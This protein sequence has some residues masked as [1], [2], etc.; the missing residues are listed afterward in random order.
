MTFAKI[1]ARRFCILSFALF[2]AVPFSAVFAQA[3]KDDP[4]GVAA[5]AKQ[6]IKI[7][8]R[9]RRVFGGKRVF[10]EKSIV[11][12]PKVI[13]YLCV[14]EGNLKI[15]GWERSEIRVYV[16]DG[17]AIGFNVRERNKEN[18]AEWLKVTNGDAA[19]R[20]GENSEGCL[21]GEKIE[22]DVPRGATVMVK[23]Q[24]SETFVS[25]I[26]RVVVETIGGDVSLN[27]IEQ[28]VSASTLQGDVT[29]GNSGGAITLGSGNGNVT[30]YDVAPGEIGDVFKAKTG[31]GA[32][33]LQNVRH[34]Q[35]EI[36]SN[37]GAI[38]FTGEF[39]NGGQYNFGTQNGTIS[40]AIPEKSSFKINASYGFGAFVSDLKFENVVKNNVSRTQSLSALHGSGDAS[41]K[42]TT[43]NGAIRIRKQ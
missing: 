24:T 19:V 25:M 20:S 29:V 17:G 7:E 3:T 27:H 2:F 18:N 11:V 26:R 42:L 33:T 12:D 43:Y 35:T 8:P 10:S 31:S 15:T 5:P 1:T 13:V 36:N 16:G 37:S 23:S 6:K 4:I 40:L 30:A 34:R 41:V 28:G 32:I 39:R 14:A 22:L 9:S 21:S 38:K